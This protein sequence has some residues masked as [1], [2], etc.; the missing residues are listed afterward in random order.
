M[1][2][3]V[4][5]KSTSSIAEL[6][7]VIKGDLQSLREEIG[8]AAQKLTQQSENTEHKFRLVLIFLFWKSF[9]PI[10]SF[11]PLS[12]KAYLES[13]ST[14]QLVLIRLESAKLVMLSVEAQKNSEMN[15]KA[16]RRNCRN[17]LRM[18]GKKPNWASEMP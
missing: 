16:F 4:N 12:L 1:E 5:A 2:A 7:K 6:E 11:G 17:P 3:R 8:A 13:R 14:R 18:L 15:F 9:A 10:S